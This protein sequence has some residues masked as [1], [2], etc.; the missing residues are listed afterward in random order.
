[1]SAVQYEIQGQK[2]DLPCLVAR[3]SSATATF[4]VDAAAAQAMISEDC[5]QV[6]EL[7]PGKALC[8]IACIDYQENDLGDYNEVSVAFFVRK[9][10]E[11]GGV[12]YLST[13]IDFF[14]GR[15]ATYIHWLPVTQSFTQEA[16]STI[17]GFPKT[18]ESIHFEEQSGEIACSLE[19]EGRH[20]LTLAMPKNGARRLPDQAMET[21]TLIQNVPHRTAFV[22]GADEVGIRLSGARLTLG[23]HPYADALRSLGLPKRPLLSVWLGRMHGRFEAP[24][25][26]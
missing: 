7:F 1:M 18:I 6:A 20:V 15:L 24:E 13:A 25:K 3:A 12:P 23:D 19:S 9:R 8:S 21:F 14:R 17:W 22:S 11:S 26:L 2:V 16:G 4:L 10:G 5:F